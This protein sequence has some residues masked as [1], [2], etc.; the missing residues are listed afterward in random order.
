MPPDAPGS[1]QPDEV[2]ALVIPHQRQ[3]DRARA[4]SHFGD[5][6]TELR[7]DG[8]LLETGTRPAPTGLVMWVCPLAEPPN[9]SSDP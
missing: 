6:V 1:L 8:W 7:A 9:R 4:I 3:D 2:Y 5:V